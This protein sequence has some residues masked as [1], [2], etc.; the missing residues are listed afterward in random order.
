MKKLLYFTA[1][2]CGP[3]KMMAPAINE[4]IAEGFPIQKLDV[5]LNSNIAASMDVRSIPC[6][7]V[8]DQGGNILDKRTGVQTKGSI[9]QMLQ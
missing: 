3:C 5:D 9:K 7:I 4:L 8:T 1:N 2:W 6:F